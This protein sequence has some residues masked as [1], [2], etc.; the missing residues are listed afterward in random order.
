MK[1]YLIRNKQADNEI[2]VV[3]EIAK[4]F[5]HISRLPD[6]FK[7]FFEESEEINLRM[8]SE[9]PSKHAIEE[10]EVLE[11]IEKENE[12]VYKLMSQAVAEVAEEKKES[13][14]IE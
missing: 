4:P 10:R 5:Y 1:D 2:R 7:Q 6:E 8:Q 11:E 13:E 9:S 3:H 12:L 14:N